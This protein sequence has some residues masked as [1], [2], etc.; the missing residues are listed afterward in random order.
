MCEPLV[1]KP[2]MHGAAAGGWLDWD[3]DGQDEATVW[4]GADY[5]TMDGVD[6]AD[7]GNCQAC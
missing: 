2:D 7:Y 6:I 5:M 3:P 4:D 1:D